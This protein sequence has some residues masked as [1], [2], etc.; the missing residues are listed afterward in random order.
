MPDDE[1]GG[2]KEQRREPEGETEPEKVGEDAGQGVS[3]SQACR[4]RYRQ[5]G[6]AEPGLVFG[7]M[8]TGQSDRHRTIP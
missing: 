5:A 4:D 3:E 6:D 2:D 1:D 8:A 7:K